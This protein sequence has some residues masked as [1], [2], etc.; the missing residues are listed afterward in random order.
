LI[1]IVLGA[2]LLAA[3]VVAG[4][5]VFCAWREKVV[6]YERR[7]WQSERQ[8]LLDRIMS[9]DYTEY[10]TL[11]GARIPREIPQVLTDEEEAELY[12]RQGGS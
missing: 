4:A 11:E 10:R 12:R 2:V 9:R 3:P 1:E 7:E 8:R 5:V 6:Q